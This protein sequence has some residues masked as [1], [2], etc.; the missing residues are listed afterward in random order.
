[1]NEVLCCIEYVAVL[2]LSG[3]LCRSAGCPLLEAK[4][5]SPFHNLRSAHAK[6]A[7]GARAD[8][9]RAQHQVSFVTTSAS[10]QSSRDPRALARRQSIRPNL[11]PVPGVFPDYPGAMIRNTHNATERACA[12]TDA[13]SLPALSGGHFKSAKSDLKPLV[14]TTLNTD[15]F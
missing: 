8:V 1:L 3:P 4:P 9:D 11:A 7:H 13:V 15:Q 10:D 12:L 2:A 14:F 6:S 5:T